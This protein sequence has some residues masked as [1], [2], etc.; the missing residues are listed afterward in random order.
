LTWW[1]IKAAKVSTLG[2]LDFDSDGL[3]ELAAAIAELL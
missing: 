3:A 2:G 1:R